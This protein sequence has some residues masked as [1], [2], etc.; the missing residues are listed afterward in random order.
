MFSSTQVSKLYLTLLILDLICHL[1]RW[2]GP[3]VSAGLL[4]IVAGLLGDEHLLGLLGLQGGV[5][6]WRPFQIGLALLGKFCATA[7][8]AGTQTLNSSWNYFSHQNHIF[9][10][11]LVFV[12]TAEMFPTEIRQELSES[13]VHSLYIRSKVIRPPNPTE[14]NSHRG[15][16]IGASSLFGRIGGIVAPQIATLGRLWQPFPFLIMGGLSVLGGVLVPLLLPETLGRWPKFCHLDSSKLWL[17]IFVVY[18]LPLSLESEA[19]VYILAARYLRQWR[20]RWILGRKVPQWSKM[21]WG[22]TKAMSRGRKRRR[23]TRERLCWNT[24][25]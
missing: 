1:Q 6:Q 21:S 17:G 9:S 22:R 10:L 13:T 4:C 23:W 24:E 15:K 3:Q 19:I 11:T 18:E 14:P 16:A 25:Y 2:L 20:K 5:E 12:Y 7:R 8:W